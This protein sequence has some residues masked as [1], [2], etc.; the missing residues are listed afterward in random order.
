MPAGCSGIQVG[1]LAGVAV[2][3]GR[4]A[5]AGSRPHGVSLAPSARRPRPLSL[6]PSASGGCSA[7]EGKRIYSF[8][9]REFNFF[10]F[11]Q[12]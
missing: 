3:R 2:P 7:F 6:V 12:M 11:P 9:R 8:L 10:F 1:A 4:R 5:L